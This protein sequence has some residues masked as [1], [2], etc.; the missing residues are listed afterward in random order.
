MVFVADDM[1]AWLLGL[2]ADA[3]RRK[4]SALILGTDQERALQSAATAA[5]WS[6]AAGLRPN[7]AR[8]AEQI[9]LVLSEIFDPSAAALSV[10]DQG[11]L[12]EALQ[13]GIAKRMGL[14]DDRGL[15][16][17]GQS[18]AELLGTSG[19]ELARTLA[20][21]LVGEISARA[22]KGGPLAPLAAQLNHDVT[23][24]QGHRIETLLGQLDSD[25]RRAL[26]DGEARWRV[27]AAAGLDG[28]EGRERLLPR[29]GRP[30]LDPPYQPVP[31]GAPEAWLLQPRFGVVPYLGREGLLGDLEA[32]CA[33]DRP[34]SIG[35][36]AGEG[37][38]GGGSRRSYAA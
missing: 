34:F 37:G 10:T 36:V 27:A 28:N 2:L 29:D 18:S 31:A 21:H 20:G 25:V 13:A 22:A 14:L 26:P 9:A 1:T 5:L 8:E 15:T 11:T 23:H 16:G 32:W 6:T 33:E 35:L 4:L 12:L 7:D 19:G 17:T 30:L 3:G 24:L 38:S